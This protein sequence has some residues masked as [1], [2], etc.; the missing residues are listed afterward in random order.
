MNIRSVR[1]ADGFNS[2]PFYIKINK[3]N[4]TGKSYDNL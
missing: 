1:G 3:D 4:Q 2:Q